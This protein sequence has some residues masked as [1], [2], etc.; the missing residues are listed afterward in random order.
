MA[1]R[2]HSVLSMLLLI[3]IISTSCQIAHMWMLQATFDNK[4]TLVLVMAWF[5]KPQAITWAIGHSHLSHHMASLGHNEL[6]DFFQ[7]VSCKLCYQTFFVRFMLDSCDRVDKDR[8]WLSF[9]W[10]VGHMANCNNNR[11]SN[12]W[13]SWLYAQYFP[14][15]M[16][17][18]VVILSIHCGW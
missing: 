18:V 12:K 3:I 4:L 6:R 15:Y 1:L 16:H 7:W 14:W 11:E 13:P 8:Q 5:H 10:T 2:W 9:Y 17:K